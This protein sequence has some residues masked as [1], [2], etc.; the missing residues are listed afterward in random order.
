MRYLF[1]NMTTQLVSLK[2]LRFMDISQGSINRMDPI[3]RKQ[4]KTENH[5]R[6]AA[7]T[8]SPKYYSHSCSHIFSGLKLPP[9]IKVLH[10]QLCLILL[11][12][13]NMT[14]QQL[15]PRAFQS[16]MSRS[17][18]SC[19]YCLVARAPKQSTLSRLWQKA[20]GSRMQF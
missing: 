10:Q 14:S 20:E 13:I 18:C 15:W 11:K 5:L 19:L 2:N 7:Q 3:R 6:K 17:C 12:A 4:V 1:S 8:S 16:F 9:V